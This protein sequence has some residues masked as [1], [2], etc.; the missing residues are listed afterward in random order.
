MK[1]C[2]TIRM[3]NYEHCQLCLIKF[4]LK[5]QGIPS[6]GREPFISKG[7]AKRI[8]VVKRA[9]ANL[10][11]SSHVVSRCE[12]RESAQRSTLALRMTKASSSS[13]WAAHCAALG[14]WRSP[15]GS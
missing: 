8:Q 9:A 13:R 3:S 6:G 1:E 10:T 11:N 5:S 4:Y 2:Q 15:S 7:S 14:G 12:P